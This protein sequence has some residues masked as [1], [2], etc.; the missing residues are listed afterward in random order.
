M[1]VNYLYDLDRLEANHEA[2]IRQGVVAHSEAVAELLR[3]ERSG[4][5]GVAGRRRGNTG[6]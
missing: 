6:A 3:P 1:M 5:L 2:F 4:F